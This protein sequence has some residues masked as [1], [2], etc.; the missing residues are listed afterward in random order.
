MEHEVVAMVAQQIDEKANY[1][2][3]T[4]KE[5][6]DDRHAPSLRFGTCLV[7]LITKALTLMTFNLMTKR[8]EASTGDRRASSNRA[9]AAVPRQELTTATSDWITA[10]RWWLHLPPL[11]PHSQQIRLQQ[12]RCKRART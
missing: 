7:H 8:A 1:L 10:S 4:Q 3:P 12:R 9:R 6:N 2:L 11:L 5:Y